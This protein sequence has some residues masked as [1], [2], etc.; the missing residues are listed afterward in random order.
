MA[1]M[2]Y[3]RFEN[4]LGDLQDCQEALE[5]IYEEIQ[6]MSK[7]EKQSLTPFIELC[8]E[9]ADNHDIEDIQELIDQ[10]EDED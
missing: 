3:C 7:Y 6:G 8:K 2:S 1:N 10:N 4:T 5:N 9:I